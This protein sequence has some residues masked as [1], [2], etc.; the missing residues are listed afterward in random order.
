MKLTGKISFRY[1]FLIIILTISW[2]LTGTLLIFQYQR[3]K[4]FR[5]DLLD[6]RLQADNAFI[7]NA[8]RKGSDIREIIDNLES[9]VENPRVSIIDNHGTVVFDSHNDTIFENHNARPEV[10]AARATGHGIAVERHSESDGETYFY[11]ATLADGGNVIR[12]AAP[13]THSLDSFLKAD[14]SLIWIMLAITLAMS[15]LA[16][17][18]TGKISL[19]I[20]RL[21]KFAKRA[22]KGEPIYNDEAFPDDELGSIASN[23]VK[24][25]IQ[26]DMRHREALRQEEEK[27]RLKKQ[28]TN[29]INHELKTP[30]AAIL[31]CLDVL[32]DHPEI[33]E[34]KKNELISLIQKNALRLDNLLKDVADITR[35]D[36]GQKRIEKCKINLTEKVDT[37]IKEY[38]IH[39]DIRIKTEIPP[40]KIYGNSRL[41]ESIF[42]NLLDNAIAYSG[43]SEISITADSNGNFCF[44]DNGCGI[45]DEHL[46]HI[47]E[48][49]YRIDKGRSRASGGTGLGL[50]IVRNAIE[51]HGG[52][53][54][55][56]SIDGLRFYFNLPTV[57]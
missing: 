27:I 40:L 50:A 13:Y 18:M 56:T 30:V 53:I 57:E 5:T 21:N 23:I 37:I 54:K 19:S 32:T 44:A 48:R 8:L 34:N 12:T 47:F 42:R 20:K 25:Y 28:L 39:T 49:F 10:M 11:S 45:P 14:S 43:A 22:Q 2:A 17:F 35:M 15:V 41:I 6:A 51:I 24:L 31:I 4:K 7:A 3:E 9:A 16:Y 52:F 36:E 33:D 55:A 46:P 38:H 26:R 29:N 1:R